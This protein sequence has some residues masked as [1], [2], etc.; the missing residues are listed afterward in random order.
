MPSF[1]RKIF[2]GTLP[3]LFSKYLT[4]IIYLIFIREIATKLGPYYQGVFGLVTTTLISLV[5]T[6]ANFGLDHYFI[7]EVAKNPT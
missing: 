3:L 6:L 5:I 2:S 1:S 4:S 7:M